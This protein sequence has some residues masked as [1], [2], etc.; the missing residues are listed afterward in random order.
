M[1]DDEK[2]IER[3]LKKSLWISED[4]K[5][6]GFQIYAMEPLNLCIFRRCLEYGNL[7]RRYWFERDVVC[8]V[9]IGVTGLN[10]MWQ[11]RSA[12]LSVSSAQK[13]KI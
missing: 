5:S 2:A 10:G 7:D 8:S 4:E 6:F 1:S 12:L 3:D 9:Q 11:S 13:M